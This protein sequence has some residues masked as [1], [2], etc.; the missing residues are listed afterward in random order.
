MLV[1]GSELQP[2]PPRFTAYHGQATTGAYIGIPYVDRGRH[3]VLDGGLDCWGCVRWVYGFE[4]GLWLPLYGIGDYESAE[5]SDQTGQAI[6]SHVH[7]YE[8]VERPGLF[9]IVL[10]RKRGELCHVGLMVA[11][12]QFLHLERATASCI[13]RID[14]QW[15][16]RVE[17]FVRPR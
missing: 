12:D 2:D 8:P 14:S 16:P 7:E 11:R 4:V 17:G 9:D 1:P 15:R 3:P 13:Q 5:R 6:Q 10:L